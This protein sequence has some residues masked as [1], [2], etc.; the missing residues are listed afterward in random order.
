MIVLLGLVQVC[1]KSKWHRLQHSTHLDTALV[2]GRGR[3]VVSGFC[4]SFS[5]KSCEPE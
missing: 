5:L 1:R 3:F 2:K 4:P